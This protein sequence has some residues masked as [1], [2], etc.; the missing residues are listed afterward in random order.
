MPDHIW[1]FT[2]GLLHFSSCYGEQFIAEIKKH[3]FFKPREQHP[4]N[5]A[6]TV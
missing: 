2:D 1:R 5:E 4:V 3:R 6:V